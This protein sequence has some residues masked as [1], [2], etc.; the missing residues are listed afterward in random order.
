MF[1]NRFYYCLMLQYYYIKNDKILQ[2]IV[3]VLRDVTTSVSKYIFSIKIGK[4]KTFLHVNFSKYM[5]RSKLTTQVKV[6]YFY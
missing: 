6:S 1:Y 2:L 5:Q 3:N 4:L